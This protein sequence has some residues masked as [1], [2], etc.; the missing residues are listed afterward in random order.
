MEL[1]IVSGKGGTGKSSIAA[2]FATIGSEVIL[3]DCD[4]DAANLY[5]LFNPEHEEEEPFIGSY[6]AVVKHDLC[7]LCGQCISVCRFDAIRE[8]QNQIIISE[9]SCDGCFLCSRICPEHAITM[10][11]NDKS[12]MYTG[13]FRNGLMVYGWLAPGEENTGKL[14]NLIREKVKK[15]ALQKGSSHIIIDGPPGT[16]CPVI[17]TITGTEKILIVTEP[18]I[19]GINDLKRVVE[20]VQGFNYPVMVLIN[21]CD[22][23]SAMTIRIENFCKSLNIP[24][25][26]KLPFDPHITGAMLNCKSIVEWKRESKSSKAIMRIWDNILNL[27]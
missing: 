1:A 22:L 6:K 4:V 10:Q 9:T 20:L 24:L 17:S 3:A 23:N 18:S 11:Q 14:V 15:L 27:I 7:N 16:A 19:S 8:T 13:K 12:R 26:G 21:K 5:L 2:A 25:A